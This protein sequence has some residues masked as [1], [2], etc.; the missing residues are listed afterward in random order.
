MMFPGHENRK[1]EHEAYLRVQVPIGNETR[2]V[3]LV[4]RFHNKSSLFVAKKMGKT[5]INFSGK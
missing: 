5:I 4:I 3:M 2:L 1:T